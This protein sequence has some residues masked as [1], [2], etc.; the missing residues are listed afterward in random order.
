MVKIGKAFALNNKHTRCVRM[1][2]I[3]S[4]NLSFV[5]TGCFRS[6]K[7]LGH[8]QGH[9]KKSENPHP[10]LYYF[11][12][13]HHGFILHTD[14]PVLP[15]EAPEGHPSPARFHGQTHEKKT[16]SL[17]LRKGCVGLESDALRRP[18]TKQC[19]ECSRSIRN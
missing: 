12:Q 15:A 8:T 3:G 16:I 17:A 13:G 2:W 11:F 14:S 7:K 18:L 5:T 9:Q 19:P 1:Q 4:C 6:L 10:D